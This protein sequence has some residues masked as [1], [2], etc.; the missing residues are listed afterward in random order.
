M[1]LTIVVALLCVWLLLLG[2]RELSK[3]GH[4]LLT[5]WVIGL[6]F[7]FLGV[8]AAYAFLPPGLG[9]LLI[10]LAPVAA[11][12]YFVGRIGQVVVD[13]VRVV[14]LAPGEGDDSASFRLSVVDRIDEIEQRPRGLSLSVLSCLFVAVLVLLGLSFANALPLVFGALA[15][16]FPLSRFA[17]HEIEEAELR[18]LRRSLA[19]KDSP[20]PI[21][22]TP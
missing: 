18:D 15:A 21:L 1:N 5:A 7:F 12:P 19:A 9:R 13:C 16:F 20:A 2:V 17:R 6:E 14:R 8:V 10:L 11:F 3:D 22:P 4:R